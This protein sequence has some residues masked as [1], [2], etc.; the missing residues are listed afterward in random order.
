MKWP[1]LPRGRVSMHNLDKLQF[2][3]FKRRVIVQRKN[4][5]ALMPSNT[6][7]R[8][9]T[10]IYTQKHAQHKSPP[11]LAGNA[12]VATFQLKRCR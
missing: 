11:L 1:E 3:D 5:V 2:A 10:H 6:H 7:T 9:H 12:T 4:F 8:T